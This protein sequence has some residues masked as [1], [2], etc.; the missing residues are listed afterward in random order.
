M[1]K[2]LEIKNY[3]SLKELKIN[4]LGR[5]NLITG[6]NNTGKST[7]LEAISLYASRCDLSWITQLLDERGENYRPSQNNLNLADANVKAF[8]SLFF[9]RNVSFSSNDSISIGIIEDTLFGKQVSTTKSVSIR[10]VKYIDE[11]INLN[12]GTGN[13]INRRKRTV[14]QE[15]DL[16]STLDFHIGLEIRDASISYI[17][18][19]EDERAVRLNYR[20]VTP[21]D[22]FQLIRTRN[23]DR[24]I[25]GKLWDSIT[26]T[27]KE[28]NVIDALKIIEPNIDRLAYI[29]DIGRER[30]TVIRLKGDNNV[31]PLKSMGDGI[32]RVLT[33]ILALVNSD[34]GYLLIDEFENGLH[35]SVQEK[36]WEIIFKLSQTL[37]IQVFATTHSEDCI[38]GFESV[39]NVASNNDKGRLLRL[40]NINGII[41]QT[42]FSA[43]E[44]KIASEN[45]IETR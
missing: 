12:E 30:T 10:F 6:K 38:R 26:L 42:E 4:S 35:Y 18:P 32:N 29:E 15:E 16:N 8:S 41:K 37:N 45:N 28:V 44:L 39:L 1:L 7:L 14:I 17:L 34:N 43:E 13:I 33:I 21:P 25:N 24:E 5:I 22:N 19:L 11:I 2:S 36:L 31:L 23:I 20:N 40:D 9:N 3:R 27:E